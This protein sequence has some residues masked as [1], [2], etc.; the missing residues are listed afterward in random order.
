LST[1]S[2][3]N[4]TSPKA[5]GRSRSPALI[6][7]ALD[8]IPVPGV[9]GLDH[10]ADI[11]LEIWGGS[12]P[13]L[14]E[15]A[16]LAAV[17]LV[18]ERDPE[19]ESSPPDSPP[20]REERSVDLVEEE[21]GLLLRSWLRIILSWAETEGFV[22]METRTALVPV[23]LC[24]SPDGQAFGLKARVWGQLDM[25]PRVREIK[26]VTFHGLRVE[27]R[28]V[29]PRWVEPREEGWLAQVIFDV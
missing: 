12:L 26:G 10:T 13:E 11:G 22:L 25:G 20:P 17:W 16:A 2:W 28:R 29:E 19:P 1:S 18:M 9:R 24:G 21:L 4:E 8:E 5:P 14:F 3:T 15:R 27:R 6:M 23:P 7:S